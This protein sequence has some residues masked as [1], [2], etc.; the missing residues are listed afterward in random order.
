[1]SQELS[2]AMAA[3]EEKRQW[4]ITLQQADL[5]P[6]AYR[7]KPA[8]LVLAA[9]YADTLGLKRMA[10][11][12]GIHIIGGKPSLSANLM[13]SLARNAGHRV[14]VT[15]NDTEAVAELVRE[16]D[17]EFTYRSVW[18]LARAT[19]AGLLPAKPGSNWN[20]YPAAMLKARA[21]SEVIRDGAGEVLFGVVYTPEELGAEHI[22]VEVTEPAP[23][24]APA[25]MPV[26]VDAEIVEEP[27]AEPAES[28]EEPLAEPLL[29]DEDPAAEPAAEPADPA[30][31]VTAETIDQT[32]DIDML[33]EMWNQ[34]SGSLRARIT[35]RVDALQAGGE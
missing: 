31:A 16:D 18:N 5:L 23:A 19:Q 10:A 9:E 12:T 15:G 25:P 21:I 30:Q 24:P 3:I 4:A 22:D 1:M 26:A 34:T 13:V 20:T 8:N 11:L 29:V 2:P 33:R 28:F 35:R 17:P 32:D 7:N 14:R 27:P 6:P